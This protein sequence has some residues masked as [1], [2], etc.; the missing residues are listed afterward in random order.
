MKVRITEYLDVDLEKETWCCNRCGHELGSAGDNYK[1]GCL[2]YERDPR[3]IYRPVV[4][5][6]YNFAPDPEWCRFIEFYCPNCGTMFEIEVLPPGHPITHDIELDVVA[7]K[8]KH[9]KG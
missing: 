1:K 8:K 9:E 6:K 2:L 3:A 7:L 4:D 5:A